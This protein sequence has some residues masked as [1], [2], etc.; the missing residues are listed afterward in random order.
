MAPLL[1]EGDEYSHSRGGGEG[2]VLG[3]GIPPEQDRENWCFSR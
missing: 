1:V 2:E 3:V